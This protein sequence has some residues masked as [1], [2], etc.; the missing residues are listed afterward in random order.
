MKNSIKSLIAAIAL[1]TV[2]FFNASANDK[3]AKKATGFGTGIYTSKSGQ[4]KVCIDKFNNKPTV[5]VLENSR[6]EV[7]YREIT[8]KNETKVRR[9]LNMNDMP[10]GE[11]KLQIVSGGEKQTKML[12]LMDKQPERLISM[13]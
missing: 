7:L 1:S 6:G 8:G 5:I 11:Y 13:K 3:E 10:S 9:S 4:I 12:E 2:L